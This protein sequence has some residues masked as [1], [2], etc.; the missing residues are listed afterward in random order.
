MNPPAYAVEA[1]I[2]AARHSPCAKSKR[3]V[4]IYRVTARRPWTAGVIAAGYNGLPGGEPCAGSG[5]VDGPDAP[6]PVGDARAAWCRE[7]CGKRCV[8][9]ESR[10][11]RT[12]TRLVAPA[13][14]PHLE[15]VH[16]KVD[17]AGRLV[18]GGGP[19]CWQCSREVLDVGLGTFWLYEEATAIVVDSNEVTE[20]PS[21]TWRGYSAAEF[22]RVTMRN[23]GLDPRLVL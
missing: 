20:E 21:A 13:E 6:I 5:F 3:G 23:T 1:A 16:V 12:A 14:W 10:A 19:S 7:T 15:A 2:A 11:I 17:D 8:H 18:A 4:A 22:H 9:A